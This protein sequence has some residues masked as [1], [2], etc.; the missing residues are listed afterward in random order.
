MKTTTGTSREALK[1]LLLSDD[2]FWSDFIRTAKKYG[3]AESN[4]LDESDA[5]VGLFGELLS[6]LQPWLTCDEISATTSALESNRFLIRA[7][8]LLNKPSLLDDS[9]KKIYSK[10]FSAFRSLNR[11]MFKCAIDLDVSRDSTDEVVECSECGEEADTSCRCQDMLNNFTKLNKLLADLNLIEDISNP[12]IV[13]VV[14]EQLTDF[15]DSHCK[16]EFLDAWLSSVFEWT[17]GGLIAW[18]EFATNSYSTCT[19]VDV[20]DG[21]LSVEQWKP[22][23]EYFVYKAFADLRISELFEI[24]VEYPDSVPAINDLKEC[25]IK[26]ETRQLLTESL[27]SSFEKRLLHPAVNT[28]DILSQ[29]VSAIRTLRELDP[30]GVILENVCAPLREYLRSRDDTIKCIITCLTDQESGPDL[31]D[32][33]GNDMDMEV[34]RGTSESDSDGEDWM[35]DPIDAKA[36]LTSKD[37]RTAD[38]INILVNIYGSQD[39]FVSQYRVLL[40]DRIL[41]NFSY[42]ITNE[43]R[44]LELLKRRFGE[45][46][47]NFCD[48][49]LK[50]I[51]DSQRINRHVRDEMDKKS[52]EAVAVPADDETDDKDEDTKPEKIDFNAFTLSSAFWPS[53]AEDSVEPPEEVKTLMESYT[54]HFKQL[55]GMRT[56]EWFHNLGSVHLEVELDDGAKSFNVTPAQATLLIKFQEKDEWSLSE[57]CTVVNA[58]RTQLRS[59]LAFWIGQGVIVEKQNDVFVT[60]QTFQSQL[61]EV[62]MYESDDDP[63]AASSQNQKDE[64]L[65]VYWSYV[66]GMLMNVG[67]LT[68]ERIHSMLRMF[69]VHGEASSQCSVNEVKAFLASKVSDGKLV[70]VGGAYKLPKET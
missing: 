49:M 9:I 62:S 60:A 64:E 24:I 21:F 7:A 69:A 11:D 56:L 13:S 29:Y 52:K 35:P 16:G 65:E 2:F 45:N 61:H 48:I 68:L 23:L 31:A 27:R 53:L 59:R 5:Y 33:F 30:T 41:S 57:L 66:N 3:D 46:H 50:D 14:Y 32:E 43:R 36:D 22:R 55:K 1:K 42:D 34:N 18:I 26:T 51:Q 20:V 6:T 47:L 58:N 63:T 17:N 4:C 67:S 40:A 12:A 25:M 44:Y 38:I 28:D 37:Q 39:M 8:L 70:Y 54:E 19:N 10:C 15:I